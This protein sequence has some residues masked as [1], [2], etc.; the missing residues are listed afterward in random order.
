M[1][2]EV[3]KIKIYRKALKLEYDWQSMHDR[4]DPGQ[5]LA[6]SQQNREAILSQ[7]KRMKRK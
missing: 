3:I 7:R 5:Y 2:R 6:K 1:F 4:N